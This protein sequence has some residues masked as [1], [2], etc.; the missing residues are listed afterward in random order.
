[1]AQIPF[2]ARAR[3][4][5]HLGREQ[6]AD[7][8]TAVSELWK[9]AWDA[10]A[11][12]VG[13]HIFDGKVP[14]AVITDDGHG[15]SYDEFVERWLMLGTEAKAGL[16]QVA[17]EDRNGL[18]PRPR[19][20][21]KGIGRLS[22]AYL[23]PTVL[24]LTKRSGQRF[25]ASLVDWHLFRN[26]YLTLDD[27]RVPVEEFADVGEF[28]DVVSR[29]F[30]GLVDNLWG[31]SEEP[32][33]RDRLEAVWAQFGAEEEERGEERTAERIAKLLLSEALENR[34]L[35][36][37]PAWNGS[38]DRGTA[39]VIFDI[40]H[41]L[42]VWVD[43]SLPQ[44]DDEVEEIRDKLRFTLTGFV[45]PYAEAVEG[46]RYEAI[47]HREDAAPRVIVASDMVFDLNDLRDLEHVV[48]GQFDEHG[49]F[50][51]RI[52][53]WGK[54]LGEITRP[55]PPGRQPPQRGRD[56]VGP[57]EICFGTFEQDASKSTHTE[58][59][60]ARLKER[61]ERFAGLAVYRDGLRVQPYGRPTS[62]FFKM[63]ER[64][65]KHAGREFW[66]HRRTF[67]RVAI[68]KAANPHLRDKAGREGVIDNKAAREFRL[69]VVQLL[70]Q[71]AR[72]FF[73]TDAELRKRETKEAERRFKLAKAAAESAKRRHVTNL[74]TALKDRDKLESCLSEARGLLA[75]MEEQ[76]SRQLE[77]VA[78]RLETL[79]EERVALAL[80]PRPRKLTRVLEQRYREYRDVYGELMA[81]LER[82]S[83]KWSKLAEASREGSPVEIARGALARQQKSIMDATARWKRL[84]LGHLETE[85][86]RW[87]E[88]ANE[89]NAKYYP[90][91]VHLI[92]DV[93]EERRP[94]REVLFD[95]EANRELIFEEL[96]QVYKAYLRALDML[97]EGTDLDA[98]FSWASDQRT[99][100]AEKVDL[101]QA[102]AQLGITVEI[103]GH[104]L[105]DTASQVSRNLRRLPRDAR[106]TDAYKQAVDGFRGL[107]RRLE[108]L[109]PLKLSGPRLREPI[110]GERID[111]YLRD[112]FERQIADRRIEFASTPSFLETTVTDYPHRLL[113]VFVNLVNNAL[114]WVTF[115][116]ERKILLDR[117]DNRVFVADSGPGVDPDDT[118]DLF[119]LFFT[120][121]VG[122]RG[123]GLYL[124]RLNLEQ[125]RHHIRY[126]DPDERILPGANFI[127]ELKDLQ[128]E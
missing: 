108:F 13:L 56:F 62:D 38:K 23:G 21:Q 16:E 52:S 94:L 92:E 97:Q 69:L 25:T 54:D 98:A 126:A 125:G 99:A 104:E 8:P 112:F 121:R 37:W 3:T 31:N 114:Y 107:I 10:Y 82:I 123:V 75:E 47:A 33:R 60:V 7:C 89:D 1:M 72:E 30:D 12:E 57:F 2:R 48:E 50:T 102:L 59:V 109:S 17:E 66:S 74:R 93:E 120:R 61:A 28:P 111:A 67:G 76:P 84:I 64:R 65:S 79:R 110:S 43:G 106:A 116:S 118:E 5:D 15:M 35:D 100:L 80:P 41:E 20:G 44:E 36:A 51:G 119:E 70:M 127:I 85:R 73:G 103:V 40:G 128:D 90:R 115:G 9:N 19:Q 117:V 42:R 4:V 63:E 58:D 122:G 95:L 101:W 49:V 53:A 24:V 86:Q 71:L 14:V 91:V 81:T 11:R 29:L 22:V 46:F 26:P 34:H 32:K 105:N 55:P 124:A 83:D 6:I 88:R 78:V 18:E 113:P 39:L 87:T 68:T 45:D 96:A 77:E 27:V